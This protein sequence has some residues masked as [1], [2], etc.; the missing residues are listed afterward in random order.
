MYASHRSLRNDYEVSTPE[1]DAFVEMAIQST[2]LG[3]RLTGLCW[4]MKEKVQSESQG[5][6]K[7][8]PLPYTNAPIKPPDMGGATLA[9]ALALGG[10]T[11]DSTIC[12]IRQQSLT[13]AGFGGC[14][15]ALIRSEDAG[16]LAL[17][18]RHYFEARGFK[19]PVFYPFQPA[20]GAEVAT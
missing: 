4:R 17:S 13:E 14:A 20:A 3:A 12:V 2:A 16:V 8:M 19:Q 15:L 1:L 9:V 7:G 11:P 10:V 18:V 5:T 6:R